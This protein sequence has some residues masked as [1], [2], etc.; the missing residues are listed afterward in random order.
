VPDISTSI[1]GAQISG[2]A[3]VEDM[4]KEVRARSAKMEEVATI[5]L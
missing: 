4:V 3:S 5:P 2:K 1:K